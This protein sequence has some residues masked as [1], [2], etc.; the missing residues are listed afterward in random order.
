MRFNVLTLFPDTVGCFFRE[1]IV[2]R[3]IE[4]GLIE[5]D[6]IDIRE[7]SRD[8]HR[9]VD[10]SPFGGGLGMLLTPDPLFRALES[11]KNRGRVVYL[12]P[13]GRLLVQGAVRDFSLRP[14]MTLI[15]GHY[16][17]IDQRVVDT[18]VDEEISIGDYVLTGGE[19]A[20]A[21]LIDAVAREIDD[22]L[23]NSGS[24][25]EESFDE[26]GLLEY[27]QYTRPAE[28]RGMRVPE[29]L[30]SGDH[31]R[32]ERW[33]MKRRLINTLTRRPDLLDCLR[34]PDA[35]KQLLHEI[36]EENEDECGR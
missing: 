5:V 36:E 19:I 8:K 12:N 1:S 2:K 27:E 3:S 29:V 4:R 6:V 26:T 15:C 33:R 34:L 24:K 23:G 10:D 30:L 7:Y 21:V 22:T 25:L 32:I 9:K 14:V 28:Y 13:R 16:E 35:Y 17:G 11:I 31:K 20:V 18:F